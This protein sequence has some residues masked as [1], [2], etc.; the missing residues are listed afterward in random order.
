MYKVISF[1][2]W[3]LLCADTKGGWGGGGGGGAGGHD[4]FNDIDFLFLNIF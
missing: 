1:K 2:I 3:D 4:S